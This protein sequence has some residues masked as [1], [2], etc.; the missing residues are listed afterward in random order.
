M[1]TKCHRMIAVFLAVA[2]AVTTIDMP[3]ARAVTLS[4]WLAGEQK[5][6]QTVVYDSELNQT[7]YAEVQKQYKE[8]GYQRGDCV[9][10]LG[11]EQA[12]GVHA[13]SYQGVEQALERF[14]ALTGEEKAALGAAA[15]EALQTTHA[16]GQV[17][18]DYRSALLRLWV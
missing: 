5:N 11:S 9:I 15:D 12:D 14:L 13:S 8:Q 3:K 2:M 4:E 6:N 16:A 1:N 18:R 17:A 10:R 7:K